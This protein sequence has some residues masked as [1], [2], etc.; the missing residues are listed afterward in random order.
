MLLSGCLQV[1]PQPALPPTS[2]SSWGPLG[3]F[4]V[5]S[6]A[7]CAGQITLSNG[8][9]AVNDPCFT[10]SDNIVMCTDTTA[11]NPVKCAPA[12][13]SLSIAGTTGDTISYVR[14]R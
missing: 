2:M 8:Q 12:A 11:P 14:V 9:A 6:G 13:G 4:T 7:T 3:G 10:A 5:S 1:A